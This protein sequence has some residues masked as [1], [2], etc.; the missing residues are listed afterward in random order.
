[1]SKF[2]ISAILFSTLSIQNIQSQT[3][4]LRNFHPRTCLYIES[5]IEKDIGLDNIIHKKF[6]KKIELL[7]NSF[8]KVQDNKQWTKQKLKNLF[9]KTHR[10]FLKIYDYNTD[11]S[12]LIQKG[13]YNCVTASILFTLIFDRLGIKY[14]IHETPFHVYLK[15][16]T[17]KEKCVLLE[18]TD[19]IN[20]FVTDTIE[21][22]KMDEKFRN[23]YTEKDIYLNQDIFNKVIHLEQLFALYFYNLGIEEFNHK[24][25]IK[26]QQWLLL[27]KKL[28][29]EQRIIALYNLNKEF[30]PSKK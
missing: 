19:K 15:V 6:I 18:T 25:Y 20:G 3:F 24:S 1:M 17:D 5:L 14:E 13:K 2:I 11:F 7:I 12:H 26:A 23:P 4:V 27:A 21:I 30:T 10:K 28:Y 8:Q 29:P 9:S 16:W 22:N